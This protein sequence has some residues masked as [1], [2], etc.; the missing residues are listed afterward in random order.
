MS[1]V[2]W[3]WAEGGAEGP[4]GAGGTSVAVLREAPC[5]IA[6]GAAASGSG[7]R[8]Q[9]RTHLIA[10][11]QLRGSPVG[12]SSGDRGEQL[13]KKICDAGAAAAN[14]CFRRLHAGPATPGA[15]SLPVPTRLG[16]RFPAIPKSQALKS[17]HPRSEKESWSSALRRRAGSSLKQGERKLAVVRVLRKLHAA[18]RKNFIPQQVNH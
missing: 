10:E 17:D 4:A 5:E 9:S 1:E 15:R 14:F 13:G 2:F 16:H 3:R 12:H 8:P 11:S 18:E 7:T 6:T